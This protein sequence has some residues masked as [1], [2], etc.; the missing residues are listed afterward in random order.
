VIINFGNFYNNFLLYL[1]L[2][3]SGLHRRACTWRTYRVTICRPGRGH[4]VV[5]ARLQLV[6]VKNWNYFACSCTSEFT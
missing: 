3:F 1:L 5:A 4:I 2:L 6:K